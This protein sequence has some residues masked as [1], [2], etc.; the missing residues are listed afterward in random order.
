[1]QMLCPCAEGD[2]RNPAAENQGPV[3]GYLGAEEDV[4]GPMG[5]TPSVQNKNDQQ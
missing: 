1:M 2:G 3:S 5:Q 4:L